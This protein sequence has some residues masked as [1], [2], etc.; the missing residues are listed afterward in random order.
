MHD[1]EILKNSEYNNNFLYDEF[2]RRSLARHQYKKSYYRS[3]RDAD[4]KLYYCCD[5]NENYKLFTINETNDENKGTESIYI[6]I[7][8]CKDIEYDLMHVIRL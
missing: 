2:E 5:G 1:N 3:D 7:C 8:L 4:A 6:Y